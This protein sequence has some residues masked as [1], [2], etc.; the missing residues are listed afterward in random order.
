M[1]SVGQADQCLR[2]IYLT[3]QNNNKKQK[4]T[5]KKTKKKT[6]KHHFIVRLYTY[7]IRF[8]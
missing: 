8:V 6:K 5:T 7:R 1:V 3:K 2:V 4:K